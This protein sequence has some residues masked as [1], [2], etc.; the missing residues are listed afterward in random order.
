MKHNKKNRSEDFSE[1]WD[2]IKAGIER[3]Y[4]E[5]YIKWSKKNFLKLFSKDVDINDP[6]I[7]SVLK[8][9]EKN[10]IIRFVGKD[11]VYLWTPC[12]QR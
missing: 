9:W 4:S 5:G 3:F 10:G 2:V 8:E 7:I 6:A 11:E 1:N 12:Q